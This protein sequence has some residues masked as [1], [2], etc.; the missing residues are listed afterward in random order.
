MAIKIKFSF[1]TNLNNN[2]SNQGA[3]IFLS[4]CFD[5]VTQSNPCSLRDMCIRDDVDE[6]IV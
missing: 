2:K 4:E 1:M 5:Q 3:R 6:V